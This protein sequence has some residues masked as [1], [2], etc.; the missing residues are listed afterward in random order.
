MSD[1]ISILGCGWLGFP[2]AVSL[3]NN[4]YHVKGSV[5]TGSKIVKL[6]SIGIEPYIID[7]GKTKRTNFASDFFLSRT[8][9]INI[10]PG[11][12]ET[13]F[14]HFRQIEDLISKLNNPTVKIIYISS[15]SVYADINEMVDETNDLVPET[16]N[17]KIL[18][19]TEKLIREKF[20]SAVILRFGGLI[21]PDRNPAK[22]FAGRTN[23]PGGLNKVNLIHLDDCIGII[24]LFVENANYS[25]IFNC[26]SPEHT[27]KE[28]FYTLASQKLALPLPEF[29][30]NHT[31][32]KIVDVKKLQQVTGYKF[33]YKNPLEML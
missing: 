15:T 4:G 19:Q 18:R 3:I 32:G 16:G 21:G 28:K 13:E 1:A 5:R 22:Y 31:P 30:R 6:I 25:G 17:G 14:N 23:I 24:Q 27:T 12:N 33:K 9:I 7:L 26:V 2:L 29:Q 20:S 10:P 8:I 11:N